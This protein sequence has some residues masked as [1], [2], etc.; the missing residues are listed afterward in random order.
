M[1]V[2][3]LKDNLSK[4]I[5][6][7]PRSKAI[8]KGICLQCKEPALAKCYSEAGRKDFFITGLCELCYDALFDPNFKLKE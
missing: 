2:E 1:K 7:I 5:Y 8:E 4:E 6:G 3:Q